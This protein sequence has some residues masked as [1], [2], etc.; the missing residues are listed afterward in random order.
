MKVLIVGGGIAGLVLAN[1]LVRRGI[2]VQLF[3]K[4]KRYEHVG[5]GLLLKSPAV[6]ALTK[7]GLIDQVRPQGLPLLRHEILDQAGVRLG[8]IDFRPMYARGFAEG[9]LIHRAIFQDVLFRALPEGLVHLNARVTSWDLRPDGVSI[10]VEGLGTCHGDVLVGADGLHS[11]VR[12]QITEF[13]SHPLNF[14]SYRYVVPNVDGADHFME[15]MGHGMSLGYIPLNAKELF[16]WLSIRATPN[17]KVY[18]DPAEFKQLMAQ[19]THPAVLKGNEGLTDP[20]QL[21]CTDIHEVTMEEYHCGRCALIGDAAHAMSPSMGTGSAMAMGDAVVLAEELGSVLAG[22]KGYDD[23]FS[24]YYDRRM[25]KVEAMRALTR[26]VDAEHHA[27]HP[28]VIARRNRK[29]QSWLQDVP[30]VQA[31][32]EHSLG[33]GL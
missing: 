4:V 9:V 33:G 26:A 5:G 28:D 32:L 1:S 31:D 18:S 25:P 15:F 6:V 12:E 10:E 20:E 17:S 3:E 27:E 21:L 13:G 23:A 16:M 30:A 7:A 2:E 22:E 19:F 11:E 24:C 8:E 14:R 29:I